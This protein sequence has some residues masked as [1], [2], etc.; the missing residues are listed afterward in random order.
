MTGLDLYEI[1]LDLLGLKGEDG[2]AP[3]DTDD[4]R[5]RALSLINILIAENAV[6][7][8]RIRRC[9]HEIKRISTLDDEIELIDIVAFGALP[10]GLASLLMLGEDD[11]L[12]VSMRALYEKARSEA[13][14]F[15]KARITPITEVYK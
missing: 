1:S 6:L 7:D 8:C 10:Y 12:A 9:E 2:N 13:L 5:T 15:G 4:L 3:S 14:K 11:A